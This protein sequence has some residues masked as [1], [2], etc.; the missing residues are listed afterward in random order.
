MWCPATL[1]TEWGGQRGPC[2]GKEPREGQTLPCPG[3]GMDCG[4]PWEREPC[5]PGA[6][7]LGSAWGPGGTSPR[8]TWGRVQALH[9]SREKA[10]SGKNT[11]L[12]QL[13]PG[14]L[15]L[16]TILFSI[17]KSLNAETC[18]PESDSVGWW[19][20][21]RQGL[22]CPPVLAL[23]QS[24]HPPLGSPGSWKRCSSPTSPSCRRA[25]HS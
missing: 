8:T 15:E 14:L 20:L 25:G 4:Q 22:S 17:C 3:R 5:G 23:Q 10:F 2:T 19:S 11:F 16:L 12:V 7:P 1:R 9:R 13:P 24:R 21:S 18:H 6:A